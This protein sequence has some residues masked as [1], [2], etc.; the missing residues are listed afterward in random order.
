M[1]RKQQFTVFYRKKNNQ[2]KLI[3]RIKAIALARKYIS[4]RV[5]LSRFS[6]IIDP[7]VN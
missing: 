6:M 3:K 5:V 2:T 7:P 4:K 1:S